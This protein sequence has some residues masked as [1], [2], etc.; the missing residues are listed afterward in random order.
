MATV[1]YHVDMARRT[2][3]TRHGEGSFYQRRDGIWI[4]SFEAGWTSR[5]T[6]RRVT[7][8][9]ADKAVAWD[10]YLAARK[11]Y[12]LEGTTATRMPSVRTWAEQW[13]SDTAERV[14]P[15][16]LRQIRARLRTWIIPTI[17]ARRLDRLTPGDI[18]AI[19]A[20]LDSAE[21]AQGTK[22]A[23]HATLME[24]L[25]AAVAEGYSVPTAVLAMR[26]PPPGV[27]TRTAIPID[28]ALRL[29]ATAATQHD[30]SRWVAALLQGMRQGEC[31]GLTWECVD[32]AARTIDV[33]W[34]LVEIPYTDKT[35]RTHTFPPGY[36][37]RQLHGTKF[38]GRPKSA[39][40]RR[41]VPL[42]PWMADALTAWRDIAPASPYDLVWP[43]SR[44]GVRRPQ[45]DRAAWAALQ[46]AAEVAHPSGRLYVLHEARHTAASLLLAAGVDALVVQ[47]VMGHSSVA[48]TRHYQH[49][50]PEQVRAALISAAQVLGIESS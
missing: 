13:L 40:G 21:R 22:R 14:R 4:G 17:G 33:S 6:R 9:S 3:R 36:E 16:S 27:V 37:Y 25:R 11:R 30:A 45:D 44:G 19:H 10:K 35:A 32:L 34:Q 29:V 47:A 7:V 31:L 39:A 23:V 38:L 2:Y 49:A 50:S 46:R 18:R 41:I 1:G 43:T 12:T 5:G 28:D 8:S 20:S 24:M 26:K 15:S 48:M 42:V